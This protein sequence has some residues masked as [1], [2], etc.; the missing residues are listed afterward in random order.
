MTEKPCDYCKKVACPAECE[1]KTCREWKAWFLSR[2][3]G[4]HGYYEKMQNAECKM[5]N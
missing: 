4:I 3:E 5:Q 2:W 1:N